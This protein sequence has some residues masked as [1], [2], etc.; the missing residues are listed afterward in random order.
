[1]KPH[2]HGTHSDMDATDQQQTVGASAE[3]T[4]SQDQAGRLQDRINVLEDQLLRAKA[5]AQN[6]Q[7]RA[8]AERNEA[9]R[10]ANAELMRL[11][12][13]VLEDF[14]RTLDAAQ[15][16]SPQSIVE[17]TRLVHA[18]LMKALYDFGLEPIDATGA[19][20]D[21]AIHEAISILPTDEV[22]PGQ[23]LEQVTRGYRLRDRVLRPARVVVS[24]ALQE[25]P[26]QV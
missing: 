10:F 6:I 13:P 20:F 9:I 8:A 25:S 1:M 12:I 26:S 17:G 14:D 19:T 11:L 23:V 2:T 15:S 5:E 7:K 21:P 3:D 24:K 4:P 16:G 18:N 22:P